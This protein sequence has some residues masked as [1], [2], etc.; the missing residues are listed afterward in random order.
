MCAHLTR[1]NLRRRPASGATSDPS[2]TFCSRQ[3]VPIVDHHPLSTG[4][5]RTRCRAGGRLPAVPGRL[6]RQDGRWRTG[7]PAFREAAFAPP[8]EPA[9]RSASVC[10]AGPG[11]ARRGSSGGTAPPVARRSGGR[12][13]LEQGPGPR[14]NSR[15][16]R[17]DRPSSRSAGAPL[18]TVGRYRKRRDVPER[19][20]SSTKPR[21]R[22]PRRQAASTIG[23]N[24][25]PTKPL[26][27]LRSP[28]AKGDAGGAVATSQPFYTRCTTPGAC[29]A[30]TSSATSTDAAAGR[31]TVCWSFACRRRRRRP[32]P[33]PRPLK[34]GEWRARP[35]RLPRRATRPTRAG[36]TR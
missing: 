28:A 13:H 15:A 12:P 19:G 14:R 29:N 9:R 4:R 18:I 5:L 3:V 20:S 11:L 2:D 25:S 1:R 27:E 17:A 23:Q 31:V 33:P 24:P 30:Y 8:W 22:P 35:T 34:V 21:W 26:L 6:G 36:P 32:S 10:A 7:R 16:M